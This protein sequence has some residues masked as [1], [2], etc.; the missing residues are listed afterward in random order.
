MIHGRSGQ[1]TDSLT[2]NS[3]E[4]GGIN[5]SMRK[6]LMAGNHLATY[7]PMYMQ[8]PDAINGVQCRGR[9]VTYGVEE[10]LLR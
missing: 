6:C 8:V 10:S 4:A 3:T 5:I 2:H 9:R 7:V 1:S